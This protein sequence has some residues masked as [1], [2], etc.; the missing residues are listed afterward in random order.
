[1]G[2]S[3]QSRLAV[4]GALTFGLLVPMPLARVAAQ[5][6]TPAAECPATTPEENK[7]LVTQWFDALGSGNADAVAALAA[8]DIIYHDAS[9][10][11][12][13][14]TGGTEDWADS[15]QADYPDLTVTV[16][17]VIAEGD[18][19]ASAQHYTGT[20]E[21]DSEDQQGIPSTGVKVEWLSMANFRIECGKIAEIWTVADDLGRLERLG[22]I[23]PD[24]LQ[25]AKAMATPTS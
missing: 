9:P 17:R 13:A 22:V 15:R 11:V 21:G 23:T 5:E 16:D 7:A 12:A 2:V 19:V 20:Q 25:D 4:L 1:M 24:E 3:R 8:D 6:A 18:L 14:E 10:E